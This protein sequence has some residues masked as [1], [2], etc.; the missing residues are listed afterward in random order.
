MERTVTFREIERQ[1]EKLKKVIIH[2]QQTATRASKDPSEKSWR[3]A[4][5]DEVARLRA[6]LVEHFRIEEEGGYL[7]AA[8]A[9]GHGHSVSRLQ[10]QHVEILDTLAHIS[11]SCRSGRALTE[12]SAGVL[13][14]IN[15]LREHEAEE[16]G[17]M[18]DAVI[19]DIG[20]GD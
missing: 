1:H 2:L 11:E 3:S 4:L 17:L 10:Q 18:Q 14:V 12:A 6:S 7:E 13:Q 16:C 20:V 8:T 15:R 9:A 5:Q 19:D